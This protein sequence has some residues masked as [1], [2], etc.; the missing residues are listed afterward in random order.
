MLARAITHK[1][2]NLDWSLSQDNPFKLLAGAP[3]GSLLDARASDERC[4]GGGAV[5]RGLEWFAW[6]VNILYL[7]STLILWHC[8]QIEFYAQLYPS[9]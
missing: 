6:L 5:C 2:K 8:H 7:Q 3:K 9:V 1:R 4:G